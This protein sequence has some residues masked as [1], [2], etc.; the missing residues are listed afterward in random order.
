MKAAELVT[1]WES[2]LREFEHY[3]AIVSGAK[4]CREFLQDVTAVRSTTDDELLSLAQ[5]AALGGYSVDGLARLVRQGKVP[6]QGRRGSPLI[7]RA[8]VPIRPGRRIA[9]SDSGH[10]DPAADARKL[11]GR[12]R[13]G[14]HAS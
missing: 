1:K 10:Y 14:A 8:D 3:E 7:R 4:L 13:G 9:A 5:A 2:R 6:N 12:R 11:V